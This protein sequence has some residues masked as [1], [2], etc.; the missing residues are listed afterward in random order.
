MYAEFEEEHG[1]YSHAIE[2]YDRMI[3]NVPEGERYQA[4]N[5]YIAKVSKLL[6]ITKT[7]A[8]FDAALQKLDEKEVMQ[9]GR[10]Y[11]DIEVKMGE[12]ERA[13]AVYTYI[14]Q[15]TSPKDDRE[16]IWQE[17]E[18]F[19]TEYGDK[20]TFKEHLRVKRSV[21]AK[22]VMLPPDLERIEEE[23]KRGLS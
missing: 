22:F 23:V 16:G 20:E 7:R 11:A 4:F 3:N 1:L 6:G 18:N 17:W 8:I 12:V 5:I 9:I 13:R 19:E 14:S 2:I 15:F 10:K 21:D